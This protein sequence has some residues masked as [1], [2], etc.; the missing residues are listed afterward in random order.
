MAQQPNEGR[1]FEQIE[2][3]SFHIG[4]QKSNSKK[5]TI[6]LESQNRTVKDFHSNEEVIFKEIDTKTTVGNLK[7]MIEK[8]MCNLAKNKQIFEL[9]FKGQ[10]LKDELTLGDYKIPS[11]SL[12]WLV[13]KTGTFKHIDMLSLHSLSK[14]RKSQL[15]YL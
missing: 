10:M 11:K 15:I 9:F 3:L 7:K 8:K 5:Y 2:V 14:N 1:K 4:S 12:L 6:Y 13:K